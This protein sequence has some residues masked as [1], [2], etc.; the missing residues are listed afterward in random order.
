MRTPRRIRTPSHHGAAVSR[1]TWH[2]YNHKLI[3]TIS[4]RSFNGPELKELDLA[5][6]YPLAVET[7]QPKLHLEYE[8]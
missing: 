3:L 5:S 4:I 1:H 2:V 7:R 8:L 6:I